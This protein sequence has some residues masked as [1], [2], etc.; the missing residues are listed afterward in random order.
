MTATPK[1]HEL[2]RGADHDA[3]EKD[4]LPEKSQ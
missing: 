2:E 1:N 4:Q 3:G